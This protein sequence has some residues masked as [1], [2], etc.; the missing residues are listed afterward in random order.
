MTHQKPPGL[1]IETLNLTFSSHPTSL[2]W[3]KTCKSA[4]VSNGNRIEKVVSKGVGPCE[5][6]RGNFHRMRIGQALPGASIKW[7]EVKLQ[8]FPA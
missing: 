6:G 2:A 4:I 7:L 3:R 1:L 8:V 5:S